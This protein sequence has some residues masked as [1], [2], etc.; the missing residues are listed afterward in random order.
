MYGL[1]RQKLLHVATFTLPWAVQLRGSYETIFNM[2]GFSES[3][4]VVLTTTLNQ[5]PFE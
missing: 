4:I 5:D 1:I 3:D 2:G